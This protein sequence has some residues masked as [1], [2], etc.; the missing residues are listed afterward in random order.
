MSSLAVL[1]PVP[2]MSA[3]FASKSGAA[4]RRLHLRARQVL[5]DSVKERAL[6]VLAHIDPDLC[7]HGPGR[8]RRVPAPASCRKA[9]DVTDID[10]EPTRGGDHRVQGLLSC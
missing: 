8:C 7:T 2:L 5:G 3:Y 9:F 1:A 4:D 10:V 6:K